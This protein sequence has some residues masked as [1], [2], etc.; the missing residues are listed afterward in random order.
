MTHGGKRPGAG[1]KPLKL[2]RTGKDLR[3][4]QAEEI[5]AAIDESKFWT[6]LLSAADL[7]IRLETG[8]Y[9][10]DRRDGKAPQ[11][12]Q[13]TDS[14]GNAPVLRLVIESIGFPRQAT[15]EAK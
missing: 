11:A 1:R 13:L 14:Q 5:L 7:R 8:K 15:T 6:D 3:K 12:M 9:L 4:V 2:A 10:T